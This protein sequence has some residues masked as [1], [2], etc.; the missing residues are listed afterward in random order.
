MIYFCCDDERRRALIE[1]MPPAQQVNGIDFLEVEDDPSMPDAQRQRRLF[2]HFITPN[3]IGTL[4]KEN[5]RI[6]GGERIRPVRVKSL[7]SDASSLPDP[8]LLIVEVEEPGDFSVYTFRLV[9]SGSGPDDFDPPPKFDPI[10]SAVDFEFK[11]LCESDFDCKHVQEC[12]PQKLTAPAIDY[13]AKDYA[14]FRQLMLDRMAV[15]V[16]QWR[17][18]HAA[19]LGVTL[20]ELLAYVG[21]YL[22]YEQ[23]AIATEAYIGT[24]RRRVSV[25]RHALLVDYPMHDG[26]NARVWVRLEVGSAFTLPLFD[27]RGRTQFLTRATIQGQPLRGVISHDATN[28]RDALATGVRV[29]EV[30]DAPELLALFPEHNVMRFHTWGARECCLPRGATSADLKGR[31]ANLKNKVVAFGE[32]IGPRTGTARDADPTRRHAVRVTNVRVMHDPVDDIDVTRIEWADQDALPFPICVS[33]KIDSGV[34][35]DVS[36]AWGNV[37]LADHGRTVTGVRLG[38]VP[39]P[40]SALTIRKESGQCDAKDAT[41]PP[42]R[43]TPKLPDKDI[44]FESLYDAAQ[45]ASALLERE[46]EQLVPRS[47]KLVEDTPAKREWDPRANLLNANN[48]DHLFVVESETDGSAR[49]RFGDGIAG[50]RPDSGVTLIATY[51]TGNGIDGNIGSDAIASIV[52]DDPNVASVSLVTNP[53]PARGG[54]ERESI[55]RVRQNAPAA[56][57]TQERAVTA[58][59]YALM[60]QRCNRDV[61]RAAARFRWTGSWYTV[62]ITVDRKG[63]REVDATFAASMRRCLDHYRMAG[64]DVHF[65]TPSFATLDVEL[66]VCVKREYFVSDVETALRSVLGTGTLIDGTSAFFNPDNFSFGDPLYLSK[67]IATVMA[68]EGVDS[69]EVVKLQRQGIDSR[70]AIDS[71][72]LE[73][74]PL[75]IIR[76]DNDPNF[77]EHGVLKLTMRGGR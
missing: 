39:Q 37:V 72:S 54:V 53:M 38:P 77:R 48:N 66:I 13:L 28:Y 25:R 60:A 41:P 17:E 14:S 9:A 8:N 42:A 4:A 7:S 20:V 76:L 6:E 30:V 55:E 74:G 71:G 12:P 3:G 29:F 43:F 59:D 23:D 32:V 35:E 31:L 50:A 44:T 15:L 73:T 10:L 40:N 68:V 34:I 56:F 19:D 47:M 62:F 51:R 45:P 11:A 22:S 75:E 24:A 70:E 1:N 26:M 36:V 33:S 64:H 52:S 65:A 46:A 63:G 49:V 18:R 69:V 67:L 16:P 2:V 21:D 58:S 57:R 5:I 27:A 61:Q